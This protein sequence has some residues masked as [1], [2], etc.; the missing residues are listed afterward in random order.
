MHNFLIS[1]GFAL[2]SGLAFGG[3]ITPEAAAAPSVDDITAAQFREDI[4]FIRRSI[5]LTHPDMQ[6]SSDPRAVD[7]ALQ[8]LA[9][10]AAA[11][12]TRDQAWRRLAT[13]NPLFADG[14]LLVGFTNWRSETAQYR[15]HGGTLFPYEVEL[16]G[17]DL[18]IRAL[19][20]GADTPLHGAKIVTI[21]GEP[22]SRI[23]A[24][25]LARTHGDTPL[26]RS[27]L[28]A[29][30][31]WF[32]YWK[33]F[34]QTS[35]YRLTIS[36]EMQRSTI[37]TAASKEEPLVLRA[38]S[39]FDRQFRF[40]IEPDG[41]AVLTLASFAPDDRDR[42]LAFTRDAFTRLRQAGTANLRI[43]ISANGGGDDAAWID[44][45]MPYLARQ[46]YRTGSTY[47]KKVLEANIQ[48]GERPGQVI[49][50]EIATWHAPQTDNPLLFHGKTVI[51]IGPGTYSS[52]ILFANV[53][54][55]FGFAKLTG[56]GAAA[57]RTQSGGVRQFILPHSKLAIWV[58]RFV[59]D[60]PSGS[61]PG[62][63]LQ[64]DPL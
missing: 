17:G 27:H 18:F 4:A 28:L 20:G 22:A 2:I 26:F 29:Q 59:I 53:M 37:D 42:F 44:G 30:R 33:M 15:Q 11:V 51:A 63:L 46:S 34:G 24:A 14:H 57:R 64:P 38:E 47:K 10:G 19:L 49:D 12:M 3:V 23:A 52:A 1:I 48:A 39:G 40:A 8:A 6:F 36:R 61:A 55:D 13:L 43:D 41:G 5:D 7:Q 56:T 25:L 16:R 35:S 31:W 60:P 62:A 21:N 50:G 9:G 45:L 58:P 54:R 32:Y